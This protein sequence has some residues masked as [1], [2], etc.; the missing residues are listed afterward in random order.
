MS[1]EID[2]PRTT[3]TTADMTGADGIDPPR[4]N[5]VAYHGVVPMASYLAADG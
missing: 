2:Y 5:I 3:I 1:G 4:Q